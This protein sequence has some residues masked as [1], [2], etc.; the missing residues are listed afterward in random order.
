MRSSSGFLFM[1]LLS[2]WGN[3]AQAQADDLAVYMPRQAPHRTADDE[4]VALVESSVPGE[5]GI[6][7][8]DGTTRVD[9]LNARGR[10][11]RSMNANELSDLKLSDLSRGT[12]TLRAHTPTGFSVR[13]FVVLRRGSMAWALPSTSPRQGR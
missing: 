4:R 1:F 13:R 6:S 9:I 7:L 12:W 11:V 5:V 8:P 2:F 3:T 10:A